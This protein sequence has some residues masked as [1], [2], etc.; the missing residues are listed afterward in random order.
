MG[1]QQKKTG[2]DYEAAVKSLAA[3]RRL[4]V[5]ALADSMGTEQSVLSKRLRNVA[6]G[7]SALVLMDELAVALGVTLPELITEAELCHRAQQDT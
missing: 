2:R 3:R 6:R 4:T 5:T 7:R 1:S